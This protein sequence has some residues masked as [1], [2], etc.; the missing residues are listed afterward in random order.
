M[1][2]PKN[3]SVYVDNQLWWI[4][5]G[6]TERDSLRTLKNAGGND[7]A[8]FI[9]FQDAARTI[10][11]TDQMEIPVNEAIPRLKMFLL[12]L[13]CWHDKAGC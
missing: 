8:F 4:L 9:L 13:Y 5:V 1:P 2:G 6:Q 3:V 10:P 7:E 12:R 11:L